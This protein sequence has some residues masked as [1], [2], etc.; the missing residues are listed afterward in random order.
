MEEEVFTSPAPTGQQSPAPLFQKREVSNC[1]VSDNEIIVQLKTDN[2]EL[3]QSLNELQTRYQQ[4]LDS[5]A[6]LD[7]SNQKDQAQGSGSQAKLSHRANF[8]ANID[9]RIQD[10]AR[11]DISSTLIVVQISNDFDIES[12]SSISKINLTLKEILIFLEHT[13]KRP[14]L[15]ARL[16]DHLFAFL[17][18][19]CNPQESIAAA[20]LVKDQFHHCL[21][22]KICIDQ[23]SNYSIG[24][25][26]I[27]DSAANAE[28]LI[29]QTTVSLKP[30][31][32]S[33]DSEPI[34]Q[35][36][37]TIDNGARV[38]MIY[39]KYTL[40]KNNLP[41]L[42]QAL[43]NIK[44]S[45]SSCYEALIAIPDSDGIEIPTKDFITLTHLNN[46]GEAIDKAVL[47]KALAYIQTLGK[48]PEMLLVTVTNNSLISP[49][50]LNWLS[51]RLQETNL[52]PSCLTLQISDIDIDNNLEQAIE[53]CKKMDK[54]GLKKAI[55]HFDGSRN[56]Q[57]YLDAI[58]PDFIK[59]D[60][61]I[62]QGISY[63]VGQRNL[64]KDIID[65]LHY[66]G[67]KVMT[68][69][70]NNIDLLP[71][72]WKTGVDFIQS[73]CLQKPKETMTNTLIQN[74]RI[75]APEAMYGVSR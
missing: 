8:V 22:S 52:N 40:Q 49:T 20:T 17:L 42:F 10:S 9:T 63:K 65:N 70:T 56:P 48:K 4:L 25:A 44:D 45:T 36:Q 13:I 12:S 62:I 32:E 34:Y 46:L 3:E 69:G 7:F 60:K 5:S 57:D 47:T 64:V 2:R 27:N 15:T 72:L 55:S 39:L 33:K 66:K 23:A 75:T 26:A 38:L 41:L 14:F 59:L 51:K 67:Y 1:T 21:S 31:I 54:L 6:L 19:D 37:N 68:P 74:I 35:R 24:L 16:A 71:A 73:P 29:Q 50:F 61:E 53:F 28:E 18:D 30:L 43:L 11:Y 58:K